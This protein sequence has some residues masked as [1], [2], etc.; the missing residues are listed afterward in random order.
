MAKSSKTG[1]PSK[2]KAVKS[3]EKSISKAKS[4]PPVSSPPAAKIKR[5]P[6]KE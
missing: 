1:K 6:T 5:H 4:D 2:P 3:K